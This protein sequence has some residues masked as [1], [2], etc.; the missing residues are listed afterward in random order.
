MAAGKKGGA[1]ASGKDSPLSEI[2]VKRLSSVSGVSTEKLKGLSIAEISDKFRFELDY[3]LLFYKKVCGRVVKTDPDTGI[4]YPVPF[5]TVHVEDT[6]C[7]LFA[8]APVDSPYI[9]YYPLWCH[10]E[11]IATV[12]T[13]ECGWFCV[14][15]P[16]WDIDWILK[17]RRERIC[18]PD[19]FIKPTI[20]DILDD[21]LPR[22]D[23][24]FPPRPQP[25]PVPWY[26]DV[27]EP[28]LQRAAE[29]LGQP[30][31]DKLTRVAEGA[32]FGRPAEDLHNLLE[33]PAFTRSL[34][35]PLPENIKS[36][37]QLKGRFKEYARLETE[38]LHEITT[39]IRVSKGSLDVLN[40]LR[41]DQYI[42]P[43]RRCYDIYIPQWSMI[44]DVPDITFRVTQDVDGDGDEETIYSEN[45]FDVR[46]NS[47][48]IPDVTL[49]AS[50]IAL[51]NDVCHSPGD[52]PCEE[53]AIVMAG[54]MPLHNPPADP[55]PYHDQATGYA[56][57]PNRP[58]PL[59]TFTTPPLP[60]P[61]PAG[62]LATAPFTGSVQLYGCNEH[63][64]A[65]YYRLRYTYNGSA[66]QTF[67][68]HSWKVFRWVGSP[69]HLE[70][71]VITPDADGW[72]EILPVSDQWLPSHLLLSWPTRGYQNGLYD[73]F[74]ELGNNGKSVIHTT[75]EIGLRIDNTWGGNNTAGSVGRFSVLRW[76][77]VGDLNWTS[78]LVSCPVI[79]R[80]A[81]RDVEIQV[82]IEVA[83]PHLRS[84][85]LWGNG[86][87]AGNPEMVSSLPANW[88]SYLGDRGMRHWHTSAFDNHFDNSLSP[89]LY[90]IPASSAS[91]VYSFH[92]RAHSRAF[93]PDGG[94]GGFDADWHY[95]PV[96]NWIHP[97]VQIAVV[98]D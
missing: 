66:P 47:G 82:G 45:L 94:D 46:W 10:R 7:N 59:G 24:I 75:P 21:I 34:P 27:E 86:C 71:R 65:K 33:S 31:I 58:H 85:I 54:L 95:N 67:T 23:D 5:A 6:D 3:T 18:F 81:G 25:D 84:I 28:L 43:F 68:G 19:I 52:I 69:G 4:Q 48:N 51:S 40:Q 93:N 37:I 80:Q 1:A 60:S 63:S 83:A 64:G 42:G 74:M 22:V 90:R 8:F 62:L 78:L 77:H 91:G 88:E 73:V 12:V 39:D 87:G 36:G 41:M 49:E 98:D 30:V 56:K 14:N 61:P 26:L 29:A 55:V 17:W 76:R 35:P 72:Y 32:A 92:L 97:N 13:D 20:R 44:L 96:E 2:Q 15:V 70:F 57:R 53:P 50:Q 38:T 16:R 79:R 89:A 11:V 9:W